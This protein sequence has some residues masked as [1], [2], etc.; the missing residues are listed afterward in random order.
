MSFTCFLLKYYSY[1]TN[2]N[3]FLWCSCRI[4]NEINHS[5]SSSYFLKQN[6]A[7]YQ[8][9]SHKKVINCQ[10]DLNRIALYIL[11]LILWKLI[12]MPFSTLQKCVH[13]WYVYPWEYTCI[14]TLGLH[15]ECT[16]NNPQIHFEA[17]PYI[18]YTIR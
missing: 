10:N 1:S 16:C 13:V 11:D 9:L 18:K 17:I 14:Y 5:S 4:P 6:Q 15:K 7:K 8:F 2:K 12:Y 3:G